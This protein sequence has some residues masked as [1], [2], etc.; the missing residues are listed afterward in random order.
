MIGQTVVGTAK[1]VA[2]VLKPSAEIPLA[3]NEKAM[4]ITEIVIVRIALAESRFVFEIAAQ[5]IN[6]FEGKEIPR[7]LVCWLRRL[8]RL[9]FRSAKRADT[10]KKKDPR[11]K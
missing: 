7:I 2:L 5:G 3:G 11:N 4:V 9:G 1:I 10:G 6:R 8:L